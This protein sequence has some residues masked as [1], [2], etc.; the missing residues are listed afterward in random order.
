MDWYQIER[1]WQR[2]RFSAKRRWDRLSENELKQINGKRDDLCAKIQQAY[3]ISRQEAELQIAEWTRAPD[4]TTHAE[5][6]QSVQYQ[7]QAPH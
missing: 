4:E 1:D 6:Y 5:Q 3:G 2:Y 7:S